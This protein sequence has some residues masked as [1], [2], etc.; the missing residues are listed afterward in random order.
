[1]SARDSCLLELD[2]SDIRTQ[3][4]R[5]QSQIK[6]AQA[7]LAATKNS[8]TQ[9]EVL[10][11][12]SQLIKA[13]TARDVAQR[14]LD[15]YKRLQQDGAASPGEVR[16]AEETLQSTQADVNLL[17]QKQKERYSEP[18]IARTVAQAYRGTGS[19]RKCRRG[20]HEIESEGTIRRHR[21]FPSREARRIRADR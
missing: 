19:V 18:E 13:R 7:N 6:T 5:A 15:A 17:E 11:L 2:D 21:L 8:G 10:T 16:Q 12:A 1:M 3:A 20:A 9:E 14:N 4:A